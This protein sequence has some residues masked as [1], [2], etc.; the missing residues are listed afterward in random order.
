MM[1]NTQKETTMRRIV[2]AAFALTVLAACQPA[3]TELTDQQRGE[4]AAEVELL[5]GQFWDEWR[6]AD[7]HGGMSYYLNSPE[8]AFAMEGQLLNGFEATHD[9]VHE[10]FTNIASQT[11]T[12]AESQTAVLAPN[13]VYVRE[14][15]VYSLTDTL[16]VTGPEMAFAFT[17]N[18]VRSNGEW[19]IYFAH[20]SAPTPETP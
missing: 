18:W 14:Q 7:V 20:E 6:A 10:M 17:A 15:G 9:V 19:K 5:H 12:F 11:I 13:V 2:L 4:L 16:G 3:T 8:F 1:P